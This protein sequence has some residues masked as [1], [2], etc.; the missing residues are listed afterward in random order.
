[1]RLEYPFRRR[2]WAGSISAIFLLG[3][4]VGGIFVWIINGKIKGRAFI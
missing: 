4:G 1:M 2:E 3:L